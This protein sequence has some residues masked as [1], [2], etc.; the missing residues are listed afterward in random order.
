L[1]LAAFRAEGG[2]AAT[3]TGFY[4]KGANKS[5]DVVQHSKLPNAK[6]SA[7]MKSYWGK[8]LDRLRAS[9]EK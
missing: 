7:R 2:K 3:K 4:P 1:R 6:S 5:Q 9:I 8:A